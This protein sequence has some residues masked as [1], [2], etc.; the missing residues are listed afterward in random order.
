MYMDFHYIL[1]SKMRV[2]K[3]AP[4][5]LQSGSSDDDNSEEPAR[6]TRYAGR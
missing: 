6:T 3:P 2:N 5:K 4:P 1:R